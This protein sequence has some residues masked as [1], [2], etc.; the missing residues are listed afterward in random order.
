MRMFLLVAASGLSLAACGNDTPNQLNEM[1]GTTVGT[2]G[3][4]AP[5]NDTMTATAPARAARAMLRGPDGRDHGMATATEGPDGITVTVE[6]RGVPAGTRAF[7]VHTAG[8][9]EGPAFESAGDHWNPTDREHGRDN[10]RGAHLGDM[11]NLTIAADGTGSGTATIAGAT[12]A[13]ATNPLLDA[14]GAAVIIHEGE[15]DYR[16]DPTGNAGGRIA[17]G[18]FEPAL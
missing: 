13:G 16:T 4:V 18:V 11:P 15:D 2:E 1:G 14:D 3:P 17:C 9:C 10:P 6:A 7:H 12:I 8:R 5:A